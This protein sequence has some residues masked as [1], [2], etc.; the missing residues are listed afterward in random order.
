MRESSSVIAQAGEDIAFRIGWW[1]YCSQKALVFR[2]EGNVPTCALL[3][4]AFRLSIHIVQEPDAPRRLRHSHH[5][6][7]LRKG[8]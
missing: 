7:I 5:K 3:C 1:G 2:V 8:H 4:Q 6:T